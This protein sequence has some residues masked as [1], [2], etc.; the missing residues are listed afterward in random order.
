MVD[1]T[2]ELIDTT[3]AKYCSGVVSLLSGLVG[4]TCL[5]NSMA[6]KA[7]L[8]VLLFGHDVLVLVVGGVRVNAASAKVGS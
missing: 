7:G 8:M 3:S 6:G 2:N 4:P 5:I 1:C